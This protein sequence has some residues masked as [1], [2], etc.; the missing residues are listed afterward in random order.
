[1]FSKNSPIS[2]PHN[3]A[4]EASERE[5]LIRTILVALGRKDLELAKE[6]A[7]KA[8]KL[9]PSDAYVLGLCGRVALASKNYEEARQWLE[10]AL[11]ENP[12]SAMTHRFL[13]D[14]YLGKRSLE[15]ARLHY[16][17]YLRR[18][19]DDP[20]ILLK[21]YYCELLLGNSGRVDRIGSKLDAFDPTEP[22]YYFAKAARA[23]REG[24]TEEV[25]HW[26]EEARVFYGESQFA[27]YLEDFQLAFAGAD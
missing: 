25:R 10:K 27:R 20:A 7:E 15:R 17:E 12:D 18:A 9:W 11:K 14:A 8:K 22:A 3:P 13:G 24:K 5:D 4:R 21:V 19:G 16:E 1:M 6:N 26:L 23:K 2:S